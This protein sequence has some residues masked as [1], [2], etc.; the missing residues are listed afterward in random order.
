MAQGGGEGGTSGEEQTGDNI[1]V[2]E[3]GHKNLTCDLIGV[4]LLWRQ[5]ICVHGCAEGNN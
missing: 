4:L 1:K 2:N 3:K 5:R